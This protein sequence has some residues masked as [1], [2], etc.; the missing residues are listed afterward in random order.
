MYKLIALLICCVMTHLSAEVFE[1]FE[2]HL[3]NQGQGWKIAFSLKDCPSETKKYFPP[4]CN[5]I[6][7][8]PESFVVD[9]ANEHVEMFMIMSNNSIFDLSDKDALIREIKLGIGA[10]HPNDSLTVNIL[11][12]APNSVIFET[13]VKNEDQV[14]MSSLNRYISHSQ[15]LISWS[16]T[17]NGVP[18]YENLL[19]LKML[20]EIKLVE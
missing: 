17:I 3:P 20:K 19:W 14:V 10:I 4:E 9:G 12:A 13:V 18:Q 8:A 5:I 15:K 2:Y 7:Y 16:Y 11:E 1:G 6:H